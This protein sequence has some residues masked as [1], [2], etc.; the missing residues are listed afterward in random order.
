[1]EPD[2]ADDA[3][4]TETADQ[5]YVFEAGETELRLNGRHDVSK[6][7]LK[8]MEKMDLLTFE[9]EE[10]DGETVVT[11]CTF[12]MTALAAVVGELD[13][14]ERKMGNDWRETS[15]NPRVRLKYLK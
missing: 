1:M 11:S 14:V 6:F 3:Q 5:D 8:D 13:V 9:T 12:D 4:P 10:R 15:W 7:D 2:G